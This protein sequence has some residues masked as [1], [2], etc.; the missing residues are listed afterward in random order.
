MSMSIGRFFK[1]ITDFMGVYFSINQNIAAKHDEY[2]K[3]NYGR[4]RWGV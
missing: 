4:E 3:L 2:E 1:L